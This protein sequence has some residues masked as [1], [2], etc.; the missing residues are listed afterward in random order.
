MDLTVAIL[1]MSVAAYMERQ[2]RTFGTF[3]SKF[4]LD[5][6]TNKTELE[7]RDTISALTK[8]APIRSTSAATLE[9]SLTSPLDHEEIE[10]STPVGPTMRFAPQLRRLD[11]APWED[12][13]S[14]AIGNK[15]DKATKKASKSRTSIFRKFRRVAS[16]PT[17]NRVS[18]AEPVSSPDTGS[19][20]TGS[21][22]PETSSEVQT[23]GP[24]TDKSPSQAPATPPRTSIGRHIAP[25]GRPLETDKEGPIVFAPVD[26]AISDLKQP[27]TMILE[28]GEYKVMKPSLSTPQIQYDFDSPQKQRDR[29]SR[30]FDNLVFA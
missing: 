21:L 14:L 16:A 10:I 19:S 25:L 29:M 2:D 4:S 27:V 22:E 15:P 1:T 28:D 26:P 5:T 18:D 3:R 13:E 11:V 6:G 23:D 7:E 24:K 30:M 9:E 17:P 12:V 20:F 8:P